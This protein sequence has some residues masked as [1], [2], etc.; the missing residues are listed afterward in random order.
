MST[1]DKSKPYI[2]HAGQARDGWSTEDRAT[3]TCYCGKVQLSFPINKG[4]G[5]VN[6]FVCNCFDC[7]K[8]TASM[9]ASNFVV[10]DK[11]LEHVRGQD[12]LKKYGQ[13][14]TI[15]RGKMMTNYFCGNC[16]TLMYRVGERFPGVSL[17]RIGTVDDFSLHETKLK[18]VE[19]HFTDSRVSWFPG[20][21]GVEKTFPGQG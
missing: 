2:P 14:E 13:N 8:I 12:L 18:P 20:V 17:L 15:G 10:E 5:L 11:L 6:T 9:F 16:G 1:A 3:A 19:E 21:T 4:R 7:R